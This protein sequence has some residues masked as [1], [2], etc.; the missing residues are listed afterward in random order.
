MRRNRLQMKSEEAWD[1]VRIN[2]KI[3][4]EMPVEVALLIKKIMQEGNSWRGLAGTITEGEDTNQLLG[5]WLFEEAGRVLKED[6]ATWWC[7]I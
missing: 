1:Y 7:T 2:G 3:K 6:P 5:M 4:K